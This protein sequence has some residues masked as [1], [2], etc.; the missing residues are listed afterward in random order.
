MT[1]VMTLF[2]KERNLKS[3][4]FKLLAWVKNVIKKNPTAGGRGG[5]GGGESDSRG[6]V[7]KFPPPPAP[8]KI[9]LNYDIFN[10]VKW[11]IVQAMQKPY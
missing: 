8:C 2:L 11:D 7:G 4:N 6:G 3:E 1:K 5:G 10:P 9:G